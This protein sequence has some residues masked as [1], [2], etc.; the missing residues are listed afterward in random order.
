[1]EHSF[2][3]KYYHE[4]KENPYPNED[5]RSYFWFGEMMFHNNVLRKSEDD[6]NY[7]YLKTLINDAEEWK[8][9]INNANN[10]HHDFAKRCSDKQMIIIFYI[11]LLFGKWW[12]YDDLEWIFEY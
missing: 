9:E 7:D 5:I 4:E 3:F 12:P 11:F 10:P 6:S 1:M 8:K 2:D